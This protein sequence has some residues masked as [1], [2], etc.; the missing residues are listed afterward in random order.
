MKKSTFIL[1]AL[2]SI[3]FFRWTIY[4]SNIEKPLISKNK[5]E[6]TRITDT[7]YIDSW[8]V[9]LI[10]YADS[11]GNMNCND[12][13]VVEFLNKIDI[14]NKHIVYAQMRLESGNY[15]SVLCKTNNNYFGMKQPQCR[16]TLSIGEAN[17]YAVY[18]SWT[19]SILDYWM[20]QKR[21]ANG[22]TENEYYE[23]LKLYC[24]EKDYIDKVKRISKE[25][26]GKFEN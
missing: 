7:V 22:L 9:D 6:I 15:N 11:I 13:L 12:S 5:G 16:A 21:Y 23:K 25:N 4:I 26:Y 10:S 2:F 24:N 19:Y 18:K 3:V 20:W 1:T 14:E 17:G 8:N